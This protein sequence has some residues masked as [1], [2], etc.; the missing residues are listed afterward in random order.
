MVNTM[1]ISPLNYHNSIETSSVF[2][3]E[4]IHVLQDGER[5]REAGDTT[6]ICAMSATW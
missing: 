2:A 6:L 1:S 4:G 3:S 5:E